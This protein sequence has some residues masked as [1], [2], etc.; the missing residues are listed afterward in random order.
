MAKPKKESIFEKPKVDSD[1]AVDEVP[2]GFKEGDEH[3]ETPEEIEHKM[4]IGG[5]EADT[6]TEEGR[7]ELREDDEVADWE[8]G[9]AEGSEKGDLGHCAQCNKVLSNDKSKIIEKKINDEDEV[10]FCSE[11]CAKAG[12]KGKKE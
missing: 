11:K 10:Q 3:D 5:K 2:M 9:F 8:E 4:H 6:T 7:E 1:E 12:V